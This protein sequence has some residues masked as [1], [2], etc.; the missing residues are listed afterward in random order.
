MSELRDMLGDTV[1]RL[2]GEAWSGAVRAFR[3]ALWRQ[4]VEMGLLDL[5]V[6]ESAGGAGGQWRDAQAVLEAM[7]EYATPLPLAETLVARR[8]LAA[9]GV[10]VAEDPIGLGLRGTGRLEDVGG[11]WR[12]SGEIH[13]IPWGAT[14][15]AIVAVIGDVCGDQVIAVE[16]SR[17][18]RAHETHNLAGEPRLHCV[19]QEANARRLGGDADAR[20]LL[21][22]VALLRTAQ[23]L[24]A[25][26][27]VLARSIDHAS[28]RRQFGKP[29]GQFQSVQHALAIMAEETAA[30]GAA[31]AGAFAAADRGDAGFEIA[32][33]KLRANE[34]IGICT[35]LAHQVHGAIGF[36]QECELHAFTQRL[37]SW[38]TEYGNDRMWAERLGRSI[39][40]EGAS[41]FWA[42]LTQRSDIAFSIPT[43]SREPHP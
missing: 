39:A 7:G 31:C 24:G 22:G 37:M 16:R 11:A 21:E 1:R 32:A 15:N 34:A 42:D 13:G 33:A 9:A 3:P 12:F 29:I 27:A 43:L 17:A 26:G 2:F 4:V 14:A 8:Y 36:T 10:S 40:R 28:R 41:R 30:V 20:A 35:A 23:I 18:H 6:P 38:R 5:L 19:F 25:L